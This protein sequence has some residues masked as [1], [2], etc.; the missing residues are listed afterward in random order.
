MCGIWATSTICQI[1]HLSC[2]SL[3]I[4]EN[5]NNFLSWL[6][7]LPS[8]EVIHSWRADKLFSKAARLQQGKQSHLIWREDFGYAYGTK[9]SPGIES[10]GLTL[11]FMILAFDE[12]NDFFAASEHS[13]IN[14]VNVILTD[15]WYCSQTV[16]RTIFHK[17]KFNFGLKTR[18]IFYFSSCATQYLTFMRGIW[19]ASTMCQMWHLICNSLSIHG[20]CNIFFIMTGIPVFIGSHSL[21]KNIFAMWN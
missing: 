9:F 1:W 18:L 4:Y 16:I 19:A 12:V 14:S 6:E 21:L 17:L 5:C 2:N 3:I 8:L 11:L 10:Y 20:N 13:N 7:Y 15:L